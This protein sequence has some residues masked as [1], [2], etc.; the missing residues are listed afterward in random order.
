MNTHDDCDRDLRDL[1]D[2]EHRQLPPDPFLKVTVARVAK[3][4]ARVT[5]LKRSLQAAAIVLVALGSPWLIS[6]SALLSARLGSMFAVT[7]YW[8]STP[9]GTA[10]ALLLALVALVALRRRSIL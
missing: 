4:R 6:V 9:A 2:G 1:F 8:L 3:A 7:A 5:V 10:V